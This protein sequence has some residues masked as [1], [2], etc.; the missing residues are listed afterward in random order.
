MPN[1]EVHGLG[2]IAEFGYHK[3]FE[4]DIHSVIK[5]LKDTFIETKFRNEVIITVFD[6]YCIDVRVVI[7]P[8]LR[9][10]DTNIQEAEEIAKILHNLQL[11]FD[12]EIV[13][14]EKFISRT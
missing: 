9:I 5:K 14:V 4:K 11:G 8:F 1:I 13:K 2:R 12:I 3:G 7:Q 6:S 10:Y